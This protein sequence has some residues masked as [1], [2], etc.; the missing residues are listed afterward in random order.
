LNPSAIRS[1]DLV[2]LT[3]LLQIHAR[4]LG[5]KMAWSSYAL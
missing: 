4:A 2:F 1:H 3:G 5:C